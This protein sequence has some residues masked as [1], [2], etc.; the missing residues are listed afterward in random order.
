MSALNLIFS[1]ESFASCCVSIDGIYPGKYTYDESLTGEQQAAVAFENYDTNFGAVAR[2]GDAIVAGFNFGTGSS[3]EQAATCLKHFGAPLIIVGS[4]NE[5]YKRNALNNG[6]I[7]IECAP[8]VSF[9]QSPL[10]GE[11]GAANTARRLETPLKIDFRR[12]AI[13][14]GELHFAFQV[15]GPVAQQL[16]VDDGIENQIAKETQRAQ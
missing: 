11:T 5:T 10:S 13:A 2:R 6:L 1:I 15:P 4:L 16:I 3:R 14:Y 7:A 12:G 9:L 8:L